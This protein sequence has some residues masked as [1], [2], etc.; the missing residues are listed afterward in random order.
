DTVS[1]LEDTVQAERRRL[2]GLPLQDFTAERNAR[3]KALRRDGDAAA[4]AAVSRLAK[5]T[6]AAWAVNQLATHARDAIDE[7]LAAGRTLGHAQ[8]A[9]L[10]GRGEREPF[11]EAQEDERRATRRLA[12]TARGLLADAGVK[13]TEATLE[14][15]RH[16]LH[17][18]A[19]DEELARELL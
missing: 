5:P 7:L 19:L 1:D 17:A 12:E 3:A 10:A 13:P 11:E 15:V 18:V 14:R 8:A 2:Y 4:A 6:A 9:L 16:T